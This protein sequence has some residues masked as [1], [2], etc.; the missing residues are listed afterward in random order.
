MQKDTSCTIGSKMAKLSFN[1]AISS[2]RHPAG[3]P[4]KLQSLEIFGQMEEAR[5]I[6]P[7]GR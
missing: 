4:P 2:T 5:T 7:N 1:F 3:R 6:F